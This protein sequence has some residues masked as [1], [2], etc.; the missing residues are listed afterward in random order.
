MDKI[1]QKAGITLWLLAASLFICA[2]TAFPQMHEGSIANSAKGREGR[3]RLTVGSCTLWVQIAADPVSRSRGLMKRTT[4]A[5]DGGM[6]FVFDSPAILTFWMRDT[7]LP[8]DIAFI[9]S[10]R[11]IVNIL[12]MVPLDD[13]RLYR[14]SGPARY[15]LEVNRGWFRKHKVK[16]GDKLSF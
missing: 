10:D 6:L 11:R 7:A 5:P 9:G 13:E 12:S 16:P 4:L 8:L 15:A 1:L 2:G 3:H 14:S